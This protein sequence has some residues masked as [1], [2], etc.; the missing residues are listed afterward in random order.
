MVT[1]RAVDVR[2]LARADQIIALLREAE[3]PLST[4]DLYRA[5]GAPQ[6]NGWGYEETA[7]LLVTLYATDRLDVAASACCAHH[8]K[9]LLP[10][11]L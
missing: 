6:R 8:A 5:L 3:A 9:W 4:P 10:A 11:D 1:L 7:R 2:S